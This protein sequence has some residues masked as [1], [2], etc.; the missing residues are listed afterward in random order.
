MAK[1][2]SKK[3][4]TVITSIVLA[5]T[6]VITAI[7]IYDWEEDPIS[8]KDLARITGEITVGSVVLVILNIGVGLKEAYYCKKYN[9]Y[10]I[11]HHSK[12]DIIAR[13]GEFDYSHYRGG[14]DI[15]YYKTGEISNVSFDAIAIYFDEDGNVKL[16][17]MNSSFGYPGG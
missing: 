7:I 3:T 1:T 10:W 6:I 16:I 15:C 11:R 9:Q 4:I 8:I 2:I 5:C 12:G 17:D 13:Y 14:F